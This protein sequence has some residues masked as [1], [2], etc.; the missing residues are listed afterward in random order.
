MKNFLVFVRSHNDLDQILP[1]VDYLHFKKNYKVKLYGVG[2][3]DTYSNVQKNILNNKL[4]MKIAPFENIFNKFYGFLLSYRQFFFN[5]R[6][7][8]HTFELIRLIKLL[9]YSIFI[10]IIQ[11]FVSYRISKF[12]NLYKKNSVIL[13]DFGTENIF[14][15]NLLI[16]LSQKKKIPIFAF[17]HGH[18]NYT[19]L[20]PLIEKRIRF[21]KIKNLIS[22]IVLNNNSN[23]CY[24]KY[25]VGIRQT[26]FLKS[27][28][29][30]G[31]DQ[32]NLDKVFEIGI[33]RFTNEWIL[34][35]E[36]YQNYKKFNYKNIKKINVCIF[37]SNHKFKVNL[38]KLLELINE[39][40]NNKNINL[41][42]KP[43]PR[44]GIAGLNISN[45]DNSIIC[46]DDSNQIIENIDIGIVYGSSIT[47]QLIQKKV[48][49]II[50]TFLDQNDHFYINEKV[51]F[52]ACSIS[53]LM[54]F[55]ISY[56]KDNY[57]NK[58]FDVNSKFF[59]NK[60][61]YGN[62]SFEGINEMFLSLINK[63]Q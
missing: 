17:S 33:L 24:D 19:N 10:N 3:G 62:K 13:A 50:A 49:V 28:M 63:K 51:V 56:K 40:N 36:Q 11:F 23:N 4:K 59:I 45:L 55:I 43:H 60:Y 35:L 38:K 22:N 42:I 1:F 48:P 31:F 7:T 41:I 52:E 27:N 61:I 12:L 53:D 39:L 16:Q 9:F 20:N 8:K 6:Y 57:F 29:Y 25:I 37:L 26:I 15:Y 14:P 34:K 5:G 18:F 46:N 47:F 58:D 32:K 2:P 44:S 30:K 21:E 54:K